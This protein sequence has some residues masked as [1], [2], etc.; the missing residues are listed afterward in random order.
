MV[1]VPRI[2]AKTNKV[3][4]SSN[5]NNKIKLLLA[6]VYAA[7]T[8][9]LL[10]AENMQEDGWETLGSDE[11]KCV[12]NEDLHLCAGICGHVYL[13]MTKCT[14]GTGECTPH[15]DNDPATGTCSPSCTCVGGN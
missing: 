14:P 8:L 13:Y 11:V 4:N 3:Q 10:A 7:S 12:R 1:N 6:A 9:S 2:E 15:P 5:M